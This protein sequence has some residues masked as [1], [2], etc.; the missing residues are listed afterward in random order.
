[1][2]PPD[3]KGASGPA[4][5]VAA[6][7]SAD[8][9][10]PTLDQMIVYTGLLEM[11]VDE[12]KTSAAL[13]DVVDVAESF[14]GHIAGR[15]N[16]SVVVKVPSSHFREAMTKLEPLGEV[17]NRNVSAEDVTEEFHDA[18]VRLENLR[19][20]RA[21]LQEFLSRAGNIQDTLTVEHELERVAQEMD[22]LE[23]KL[24]FMKD[25]ATWSQITVNV[26]PKPKV[27][28]IVKPPPPP[29][30]PPPDARLLDLPVD[31]IDQLGIDRLL[32]L[33]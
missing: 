6:K 18:E 17:V 8:A 31:W 23:G 1:M 22:V 13:D 14:G 11:L 21:R 5:Q 7:T 9:P 10:R 4:A 24:A 26:Q 2:A 19:A 32:K 33:K 3:G 15:T 30:P 20:T 16:G 27:A 28:E 29:P 12:Q 25:R